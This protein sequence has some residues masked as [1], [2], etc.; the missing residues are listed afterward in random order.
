M[1]INADYILKYQRFIYTTAFKYQHFIQNESTV[2]HV[3]FLLYS[4]SVKNIR[5]VF[6]LIYLMCISLISFRGI[7]ND[8]IL[9]TTNIK[10]PDSHH[11]VGNS[12]LFFT[13]DFV[14]I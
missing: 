9:R 2:F 8:F 1:H 14:A 4:H 13:I 12:C 6:N 5:T 11:N 3:S 7:I 10:F